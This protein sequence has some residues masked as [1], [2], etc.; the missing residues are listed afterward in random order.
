MNGLL[1]TPVGRQTYVVPLRLAQ[2]VCVFA[3]VSTVCRFHKCHWAT[4][5]HTLPLISNVTYSYKHCQIWMLNFNDCIVWL[6]TYIKLTALL[7]KCLNVKRCD[8]GLNNLLWSSG[9]LTFPPGGCFVYLVKV[10]VTGD[11]NRIAMFSCYT[12]ELTACIWSPISNFYQLYH[13][14][15]L[16]CFMGF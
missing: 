6:Y 15:Y 4:I 14:Q 10:Y 1:L 12:Q 5:T 8:S 7:C 13:T 2:L 9:W 16:V 11:K 3:S